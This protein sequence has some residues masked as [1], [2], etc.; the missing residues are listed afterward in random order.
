MEVGVELL[1]GVLGCALA[2]ALTWVIMEG[3]F[4]LT[5]GRWR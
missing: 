2:A 3:I 5:F 1:S 4:A